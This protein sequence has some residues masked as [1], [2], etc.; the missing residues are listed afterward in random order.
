MQL[1]LVES[2]NRNQKIDYAIPWPLKLAIFIFT[3]V[4]QLKDSVVLV[5]GSRRIGGVVATAVAAAGA[6]VALSYHQS[7]EA[8][9]ETANA[10][11]KFGRRAFVSHADLT[12]EEDCNSLVA[13]TVQ[14]LGRL[15]VLV[16]MASVYKRTSYDDLTGQDWDLGL[17]VDLKAAFL[18]A[19]AATP[20]MSAVGGGRIINVS[21]WTAKSGR[22]TYLGYIPYYVAKVGVIG[23]TEALALELADSGILVN[24]IA[25][26]PIRPPEGLPD[27]E[28]RA[29]E[30]ATP[31]GRWGGDEEIVKAVLALIETDFIT[32]ETVRV[33]GGRH[34]L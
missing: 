33:D 16:N 3:L 7:Q 13:A 1:G 11:R 27:A 24:A 25:P 32:G 21:D 34:L 15:D 14:N 30:K 19:R 22:P 28:R 23:L 17:A 12:V 9:E 26:G 8:V 29:V 10:I 20:H 2:P 4:M 5:T 31:A 6:D 18:C